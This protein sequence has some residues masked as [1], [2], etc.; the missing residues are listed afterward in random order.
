MYTTML[1]STLRAIAGSYLTKKERI[2]AAK[3]ILYVHG[4]ALA[5]AGV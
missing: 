1:Q 3:Q 4:S 5:M 2:I